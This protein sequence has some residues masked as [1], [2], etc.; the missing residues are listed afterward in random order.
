MAADLE[1]RYIV[2]MNTIAVSRQTAPLIFLRR[3]IRAGLLAALVFALA[4]D[5]QLFDSSRECRGA[6]SSAFSNGFDVHRCKL[7]IKAVGS[8]FKFAVPLPE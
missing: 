1:N 8:D 5:A 2:G 6:F 3:L 7:T 4:R